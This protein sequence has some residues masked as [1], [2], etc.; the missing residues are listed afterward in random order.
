MQRPTAT[1]G[2]LTDEDRYVTRGR[3]STHPS[4]S[5]APSWPS[6]QLLVS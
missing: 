3:A 2:S 4:S 1:G 5:S 6:Q